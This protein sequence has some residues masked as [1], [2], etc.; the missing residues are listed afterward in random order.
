MLLSACTESV[1]NA[2]RQDQLPKIFPDYIGVTIPENIAP[3]NFCV[4]DNIEKIDVTVRGSNGG[5]MHVQDDYA[6]FDIDEWHSIVSQNKGGKLTFSVCVKK[7]GQW[8]RYN[9]F[10][11]TVSQ[12]DMPDYALTYRRIAPGYEVYSKMGLYERRLDNFDER[13]LIENTQ[14]PGMCVNCHT[15]CKTNPDN[16]VFHIRGDHGGT[17]FKTGQKTEILKAKN[18]SIKGSMVYPYWHPSGKYC[19]FSTNMTRQG[20]HMVKDERVEVFDLSSDIFVYDVEKHERM[21]DT[22]LPTIPSSKNSP[23]F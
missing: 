15:S 10:T 5:E 6:D 22:L 14:V 17:L 7:G 21:V 3:M 2:A 8:L 18:D 11:M 16:Y 4:D 12:Y 20:F 1:D 23:L 9:D 13:A 19:T